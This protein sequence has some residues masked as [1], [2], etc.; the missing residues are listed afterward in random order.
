MT[1][2]LERSARVFLLS[3]V[4]CVPSFV[5]AQA[6]TMKAAVAAPATPEA[7]AT[8]YIAA[9]RQAD[10]NTVAALMH[11][12]ALASLRGLV[13]AMAK[14]QGSEQFMTQVLGGS[15]ADVAKLSDQQLFARF[16]GGTLGANPDMAKVLGSAKGTVLGHVNEGTDTAH[17]LYRMRMSFNGVEMAKVDVLS[18][19]KDGAGWRALLTADIENMIT[20]MKAAS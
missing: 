5:L 3:M 11:P 14:K 1:H 12:R 18:A 19:A 20:Q 17:V 10:W 15:A 16:I 7:L 9:M 13:N 8:Q 2:R 4:L 6:P